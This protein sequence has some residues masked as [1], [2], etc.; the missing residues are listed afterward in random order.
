MNPDVNPDE[1]RRRDVTAPNGRPFESVWDYPRPPRLERVERR[2]RIEH[3]GAVVVDAPWAHRVLETSQLP[4]Y[5]V[6]AEFVDGELLE[7]SPRRSMCE[8]KGLAVYADVVVP[9]APV[10][11]AAAW[12]YP[13]PTS[14]FAAIAGSWAFYAQLLD[15]CAVDGE[16]VLPNDGSFYGGWS[17]AEIVGPAKG[18]PG[19]SHW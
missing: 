3:A 13:E 12:S 2:I 11:P 6:A 5:Y 4:A 7:A 9:G 16:V 18:A 10:V 19:T 1:A 8:W 14:A 17:T 15:R